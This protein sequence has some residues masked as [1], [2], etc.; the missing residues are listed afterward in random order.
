[1]SPTPLQL[2]HV[3]LQTGRLAEMREFYLNVLQARVAVDLPNAAFLSIDEEHHRFGIVDFGCDPDRAPS[4]PCMAHS[5][6]K[7]ASLDDLLTNF[8]RLRS[9]GLEPSMCV[10]HGPTISLYYDDPDGNQIELFVD[11]FDSAQE[12]DDFMH[13]ETFTTNPLGIPFDPAEMLD[14]RRAGASVSE[15][16]AYA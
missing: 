5:A 13:T 6:F 9:G 1:M 12:A 7:N 15:L 10:N 14:R 11:V 2:S 8:D 3:V 16:T 4:A